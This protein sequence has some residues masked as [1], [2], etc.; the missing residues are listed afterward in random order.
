MTA[1]SA[2]PIPIFFSIS[3]SR[4]LDPMEKVH[5]EGVGAE[6]WTPLTFCSCGKKTSRL[7]KNPNT[8]QR[9]KRVFSAPFISIGSLND[10][11]LASSVIC[12][13]P[14]P[15]Q[16]HKELDTEVVHII[17]MYIIMVESSLK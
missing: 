1:A 8:N 12:E 15:T 2:S 5:E 6:T 16:T 9:V 14:S 10:L 13:N 3:L 7:K 17:Y 4:V 11:I